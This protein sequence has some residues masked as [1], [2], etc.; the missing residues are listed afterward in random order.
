MALLEALISALC[1][2]GQ[3]QGAPTASKRQADESGSGGSSAGGDASGG[4]GALREVA[5]RLV[6]EFLDWSARHVAG[7]SGSGGGR[8]GGGDG[9]DELAQNYNATSLLRR[10]FDRL[11]H[12]RGEARLGAAHG[13]VHCA[14]CVGFCYRIWREGFEGDCCSHS[15]S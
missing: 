12:P 15:D 5:A 11:A 10:L 14:R 13:M 1:G 7:G 9:G 6:G 2:D 3:Q 8:G 4:S